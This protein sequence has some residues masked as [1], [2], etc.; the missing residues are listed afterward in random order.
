MSPLRRQEGFTLV[1]L[2]VAMTMSLV[3]FCAT[4]SILD[5]YLHQSSAAGK[6][7]DAQD[8]AR[9]AVDRIVRD[10]RN[11]SSPLTTP[12]L[13]ERATPNDVV[14]QTI[15]TPSGANVSGIQRVRY[16]VPQDSSSGSASLERLI[17]QTQTWTTATPAANPWTSD[18]SQ[19][20]ACPDLTFTPAA[21]Q[22]VYTVLA[23]A[24]MNR[25]R[26][27]TS[28]PAF[29]FNNGLDADGVA[30]T[31]LPQIS[32]I[33][34]NLRVNPTP[35]LSGATTQIRSAAYLRNKQHAPVAQFTYTA[36]GSGGV[37]LNAGQSYSPDNEQLSYA[38]ACTSSPCPSASSL[39]IASNGL[40]SWQPGA[41]TYT[42]ALT[43]T[44][45]TGVQT[46]TTQ[47][48]TVT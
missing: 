29:S 36:T 13:L 5:S 14:F 2:L 33:Q 11:V 25:Y 28:Y 30:A 20:I 15:G 3:V 4:L 39:A 10:L 46:T 1:E 44:D 32:T 7:L 37:I 35:T 16:C 17:A 19:T 23:E 34:V 27:T 47:Q 26:Q 6:R 38:W 9:L 40:V 24:V 12:K 31:D 8:R 48:V 42:V 45:Q 21:G 43:V 18:P 41:G 22:P